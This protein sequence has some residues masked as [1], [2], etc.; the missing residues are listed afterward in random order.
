[1]SDE[2][3][4]QKTYLL[5]DLDVFEVSL[6]NRPANGRSFY[7]TKADQ[8][9][10]IMNEKLLAL[11]EAAG[12]NEAALDAIISK[13]MS[14]DGA[15]AVRAA[16]RLLS[17]FAE[18]VPAEA[19][20]MLMDAIGMSDEEKG[21]HEDEEKGMDETDKMDDE[22]EAGYD[23]LM[24][25]DDIPEPLR[26]QLA[27]LWKSNQ[28][29]IAKAA[30]LE[31]VL[32]AE[33]DAKHLAE[34]TERVAKSFGHVP[35]IEAGELATLLINVRKSDDSAADRIES[36]LAAAETALIAKEAGALDETGSTVPVEPGPST[37]QGKLEALA[38]G[39][40]ERGEATDFYTAFSAVM[41]SPEGK[42]L[43]QNS[44][45]ERGL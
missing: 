18:E 9:T 1:M 28:E 12:E 8:G 38:K 40:V 7:L 35:G 23:N 45:A 17:G 2:K 34:E 32:K 41:D 11:I 4:K 13:E 14:E 16:L 3:S 6:V 22:K 5:S 10:E 24:K 43:Y 33:R 36:V 20:R 26:N 30:E 29:A 44:K 19:M 25:S 39:M 21:A 15:A 27:E 31:S 37:S 42:E